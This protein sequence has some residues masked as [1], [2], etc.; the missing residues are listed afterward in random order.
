MSLPIIFHPAVRGD[1][2]TAYQFYE[3]RRLGLGDGFLAA[4]DDVYAQLQAMP[5]LYGVVWRNVRCAPLH[6]FPY[7]VYYQVDANQLYVLAVY[8]NRQN[9]TGWQRRVSSS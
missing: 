6:R 3:S 5:K 8:H 7:A 1:V 2:D 9:P 4:V